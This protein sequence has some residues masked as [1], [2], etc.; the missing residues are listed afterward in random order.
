MTKYLEILQS[1]FS[2]MEGSFL[3]QLRCEA[4][5]D[6]AAFSCLTVAMR[7]YAADHAGQEMIERWIAEGFWSVEY[8]VQDW[9]DQ[10]WFRRSR[11]NKEYYIQSLELVRC[12]SYWLFVGESP[13][14]E[15]EVPVS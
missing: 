11:R 3:L 8:M 1:E 5:W 7:Q 4:H 13:D 2:A 14:T 12:L 10:P 15:N 6:K 9:C